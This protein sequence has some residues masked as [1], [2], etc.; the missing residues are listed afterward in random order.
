MKEFNNVQFLLQH[1]RTVYKSFKVLFIGVLFL[2][3]FKVSNA[4]AN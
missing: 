3:R 4:Y 1:T 2:V